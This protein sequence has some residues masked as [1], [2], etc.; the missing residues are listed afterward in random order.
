MICELY[1]KMHKIDNDVFYYGE[2]Q[3]TKYRTRHRKTSVSL[4]DFITAVCGF[5]VFS[6]FVYWWMYPGM[7][8]FHRYLKWTKNT[9][10]ECKKEK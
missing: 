4:C 9:M 1:N 3:T 6:V 10:F 2:D 8:F 5:I 7:W